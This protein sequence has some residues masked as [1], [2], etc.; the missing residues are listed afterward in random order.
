[1]KTTPNSRRLNETAREI[2]ASILVS[3]VSDPRLDLI[4]VTGAEVSP[5]RSMMSVYV[6]TDPDRYDEVLA[7]LESAKGR[8]RSLFGSAISWRVTPE[9]RFFID[10]SVDS[11]MRIEEALRAVPP[12][13][14]AERAAGSDES[15]APEVDTADGG[16]SAEAGE[17]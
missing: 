2:V 1:M 17:A 5:D 8:I 12:S 16:G 14:A 7:G 3:E 6:S 10:E 4:T 13:L 9:V 15:D 11:G